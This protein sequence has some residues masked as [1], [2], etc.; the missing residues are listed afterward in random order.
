MHAGLVAL[1][2]YYASRVC[3]ACSIAGASSSWPITTRRVARSSP[4]FHAR[5]MARC[6]QQTCPHP[7]RALR[8]C[9]PNQVWA[10]SDIVRASNTEY[11]LRACPTCCAHLVCARVPG[12]GRLV[13][14]WKVLVTCA[15]YC[16]LGNKATYRAGTAEARPASPVIL[17]QA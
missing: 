12:C 6:S 13:R 15:H 1:I 17:C 16:L 5:S 3:S 14:A 2:R 4:G 7:T 11:T 9:L 8:L 10:G